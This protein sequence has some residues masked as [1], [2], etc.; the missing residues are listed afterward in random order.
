LARRWRSARPI[1]E[2]PQLAQMELFMEQFSGNWQ[3]PHLRAARSGMPGK[4]ALHG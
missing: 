4:Q 2:G 3:L 1:L